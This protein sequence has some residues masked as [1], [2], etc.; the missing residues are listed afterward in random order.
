MWG[1]GGREAYRGHEF[2][3]EQGV[4]HGT[5]GNVRL[6]LVVDRERVEDVGDPAREAQGPGEIVAQ[7]VDLGLA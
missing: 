6:D 4:L 7:G 3:G 5:G 2:V 1:E